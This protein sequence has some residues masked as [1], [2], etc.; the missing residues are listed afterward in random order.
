MPPYF[1]GEKSPFPQDPLTQEKN[2]TTAKNHILKG[3]SIL[4]SS[5]PDVKIFWVFKR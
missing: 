4:Y 1:A 2:K 5:L 3:Y